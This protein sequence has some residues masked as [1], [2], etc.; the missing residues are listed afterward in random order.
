[1]AAEAGSGG[2]HTRVRCELRGGAAAGWRCPPGKWV[3]AQGLAP[4]LREGKARRG[5]QKN[6]K[7][8]S[9]ATNEGKQALQ[10]PPALSWAPVGV[11]V[12]GWEHP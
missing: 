2:R 7:P 1:V 8:K 12:W 3:R 11:L 9:E 10:D 4:F 5:K 6:P